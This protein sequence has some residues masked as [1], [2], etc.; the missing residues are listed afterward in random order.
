MLLLSLIIAEAALE[1]VP[2]QIAKQSSVVKHA[3]RKGK[4]AEEILLD[5]SYHHN[6]MLKLENGERRGRPDLVHFALLEATST[7]LYQKNLLKVY[8]HTIANKVIFLGEN[9]RLPKSY[10]RFEGLIEDLFENG[11]VSSGSKMLMDLKDM[12]FQ[13]LV[14]KLKPSKVIG[15]SRMGARSSAEEVATMIDNDAAIVVGGFP[16]G[17][18]S[19]MVS[20]KINYTYSI[21]DLAL[22][23]HLVIARI[24]YECEKILFK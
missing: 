8:I 3:A 9:V 2:K 15:L 14:D 17:H 20:S 16:R 6:A 12:K 23:A 13:D 7:P 11:K 5:R 4:P 24:L 19:N 18:F 22:E 1:T 21:S 10:F